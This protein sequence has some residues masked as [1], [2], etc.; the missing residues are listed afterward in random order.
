MHSLNKAALNGSQ[1]PVL[2]GGAVYYI[3]QTYAG[4]NTHL[5]R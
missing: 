4:P 2:I 1:F 5:F 3:S